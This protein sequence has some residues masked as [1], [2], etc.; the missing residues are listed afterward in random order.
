MSNKKQI[1][2]IVD[3]EPTNIEILNEA[4]GNQYE[5]LA[6]TNGKDVMDITVKEKPDIILLDIIMPEPGGFE[7]IKALKNNVLTKDIPVI[8]ITGLDKTEE[9]TKGLELGAVD[10]IVKPFIPSIARLR[11]KNQLELK[12]HRDMLAVRNKELQE[13]LVKVKTLSG[14]LP[15]C[16]SCKRIR[17]DRGYWNQIEMYIRDHSEADFSHG[18]CP[19]CAKKLYPRYFPGHEDKSAGG[20]KP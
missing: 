9:E 12:S 4:L 2:L 18:L 6:T 3:D 10:Y 1:V 11:V 13:A 5:I 17:D 7:I 20:N 16:S 14:L 15:I 8:F 19:E